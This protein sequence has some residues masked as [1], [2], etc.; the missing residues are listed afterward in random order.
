[1]STYITLPC[2]HDILPSIASQLEVYGMKVIF[3]SPTHGYTECIS[4]KLK[5][6]HNDGNLI[7]EIVE[8]LGHFTDTIIIGGIR[9][10]VEEIMESRNKIEKSKL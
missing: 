7:V 8:N 9:Q 2:S 10:V 4:G 6:S 5:F 1:M 3:S